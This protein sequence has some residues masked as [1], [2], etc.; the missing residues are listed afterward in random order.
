MNGSD[1]Q[2]YLKKFTRAEFEATHIG[3][4]VASCPLLYQPDYQSTRKVAGYS[5]HHRDVGY[6]VAV[7]PDNIQKLCS[8]FNVTGIRSFIDPTPATACVTMGLAWPP[9][10]DSKYLHPMGTDYDRIDLT[11]AIPRNPADMIGMT[12]VNKFNC[13]AAIPQEAGPDAD[14]FFAEA[15]SIV[16]SLQEGF[17]INF[18]ALKERTRQFHEDY[19]T[20][21]AK[22]AALAV[23]QC[24]ILPDQ[25]KGASIMT[26]R[27]VSGSAQ[28]TV[29]DIQTLA[30]S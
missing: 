19:L 28:D 16:A 22:W 29:Y 4:A 2:P 18:A 14:K 13:A 17:L 1:V 25:A 23:K 6:E 5:W 24:G 3:K 20:D 12:Q 30:L 26:R 9:D 7:M 27:A 15:D 8:Y 21:T 10:Q 11:F